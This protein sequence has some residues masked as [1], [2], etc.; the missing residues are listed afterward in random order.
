VFQK[1]VHEYGPEMA[2]DNDSETRW[3][4]DSGTK[5]AWITVDL[6]KPLTI[7]RVRIEEAIAERVQKFEFQCRDGMDWK[8]IFSSQK[9]GRWFQKRL[10]Q[11]ITA[12]EFRLNILDATD[13]PTISDIEFI[14]Q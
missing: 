1:Q 2:F 13:G 8:T 3:A 7:Q 4:T 12:R 11:P 10:D 6:G 5:Q 14:E 9:I